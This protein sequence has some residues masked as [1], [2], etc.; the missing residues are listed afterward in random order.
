MVAGRPSDRSC[1]VGYG[2]I[3]AV[4]PAPPFNLTRNGVT[5]ALALSPHKTLVTRSVCRLTGKFW[6]VVGNC[7]RV[8]DPP[9]VVRFGKHFGVFDRSL[10]RED[11]R[12]K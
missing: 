8:G 7:F 12:G 2:L 11:N 5:L 3:V 9:G 6:H 4:G 1:L 10:D